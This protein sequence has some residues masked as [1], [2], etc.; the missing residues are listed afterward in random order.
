M[1]L[2]GLG[3]GPTIIGF[4]ND[5][6]TPRFGIE[7]IRVSMLIIG[8]PHVV[9]AVFGILAARTL[10]EDLAAAKAGP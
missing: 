8:V 10:R 2:G 9:A 3:L 7:A 5:W 4:M 1:N 6:L